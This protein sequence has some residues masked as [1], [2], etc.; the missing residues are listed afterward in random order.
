MEI[1]DP[2]HGSIELSPLEVS[3]CNSEEY[4]RLRFIKQ[5][6]FTEF[7]FPGAT[8]NR[9]LHSIG[10]CY[11]AGKAFDFIFKNYKFDSLKTRSSL[12]QC[13]KL[14]ALLHD[15]GHGPLSHTTEKAMPLLSK[16]NIKIYK[17]FKTSLENQ[18]AKHEDYTIAFI[19]ESEIANIIRSHGEFEPL[20]VAALMD[21]RIEIKD[22]FFKILGIDF[23]VI[24][25]QLISS[26]LDVDRMDYL[27]RDAYFCGISY[28]KIELSWLL[29]NLT[30]NLIE[31]CLHLAINQQALYTFDDFLLSR[32]HMSLM[33][34]F[35]HKSIIYEQMLFRYFTSSDCTFQLP[36]T[37]DEYIKYTDSFLYEHLHQVQ[38]SNPWAQRIVRRT[39]YKTLFEAHSNTSSQDS[40]NTVNKKI[41]ELKS[42]LKS[43]DIDFILTHSDSHLSKYQDS[44]YTDPTHS[45]YVVEKYNP[46]TSP[47]KIQN[48]TEIFDRYK[49]AR[50][51]ERLYVAPEDQ[52]KARKIVSY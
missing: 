31:N 45:I 36:H 19:T 27:I 7:S 15:V 13:T 37:L 43:E 24:L 49:K 33:V 11:L 21:P 12:R 42:R 35:H 29:A 23:R 1:R 40:P 39:P 17:N 28:G 50:R 51:I 5:L 2:I 8:H 41:E 47:I 18:K 48:A 6:G 46:S 4:Q 38:N 16:L 20:H 30:Y 10:A 32:H 9:F 26:E 34:Y 52:D 25:N 3:I 44:S 14:A 22:D